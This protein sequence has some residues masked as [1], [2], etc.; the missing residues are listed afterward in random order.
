MK[1][2]LFVILIC[3]V[4]ATLPFLW[5]KP[6]EVNFGGDSSRL[7]LYDPAN[8]LKNVALYNIAPGETGYEVISYF[9]IPFTLLLL[10]LKTIFYTP[11]LLNTSYTSIE[12]VVAFLFMY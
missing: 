6:G 3:V 12:I 4:L 8:Y 7:Y 1:K 9:Y 2:S 10:V 5:F 11:Y